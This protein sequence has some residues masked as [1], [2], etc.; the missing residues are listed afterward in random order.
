MTGGSHGPAPVVSEVRV[1]PC[2]TSTDR[3][4]GRPEAR[5]WEV[6]RRTG[7][8]PDTGGCRGGRTRPRIRRGQP[9]PS[10]PGRTPVTVVDRVSGTDW[11]PSRAP[12][13]ALPE[14][15]P[16]RGRMEARPIT[17]GV[18]DA[19]RVGRNGSSTTTS[20]PRLYQ[21]LSGVC[22]RSVCPSLRLR[23]RPGPSAGDTFH[24]VGTVALLL[25]STEVGLSPRSG[26]YPGVVRDGADL[27]SPVCPGLRGGC[28]VL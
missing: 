2:A 21:S 17:V 16:R 11:V 26:E 8:T 10:T 19:S 25:G 27:A 12:V 23:R 18:W 22:L 15:L 13:D 20:A 5:T 7:G 1:V 24:R 3:G 4:R 28:G 9:L 14:L 6:G